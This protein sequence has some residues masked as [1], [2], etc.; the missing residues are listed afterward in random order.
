MGV[1]SS[2]ESYRGMAS[3]LAGVRV[4]VAWFAL[5]LVPSAARR[6]GC[7]ARLRVLSHTP[8]VPSLQMG[9]EEFNLFREA[10]ILGKFE[11]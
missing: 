10:E 4:P 8:P 9:E 11:E 7:R 3:S 6:P 1:R 2:G 5:C